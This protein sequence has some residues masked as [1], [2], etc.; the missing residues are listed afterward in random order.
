[1]DQ[2]D[3]GFVEKCE[4]WKL[5]SRFF[6]NKVG[7]KPA[8]LDLKDLP[9]AKHVECKICKNPCTFL[10]QIYAPYENNDNAF[11]RTIFIF[12]CKNDTCCKSNENGNLQVLRSQ[13]RR[14]NKFYP[15]E[16]PE[17]QENWRPDIS[18]FN[19]LLIFNINTIIKFLFHYRRYKFYKNL[20]CLW[21]I[22][23]K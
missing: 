17:E 23:F 22:S 14:D 2:I 1:M 6:P 11:H 8:W 19:I 10:C 7:G 4:P 16:P 18:T 3:I 13:L 15:L 9:S 21:I 5:E 12:I 20:P